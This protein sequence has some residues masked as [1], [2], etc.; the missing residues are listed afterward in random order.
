MLEKELA[1][2]NISDAERRNVRAAWALSETEYLR[3]IRSKV[4]VGS[5]MKIKTIGHGAFGVV[6]LVKEKGSGQLYAM[7]QLRK[8]EYVFVT[9]CD[10]IS[11]LNPFL[12]TVCSRKVKKDMFELSATCWHPLP[13]KPNGLFA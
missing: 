3:D 5:F 11:K 12:F 9:V 10:R 7:K 6:S 13:Q 1:R 8:A 2:L 4:G